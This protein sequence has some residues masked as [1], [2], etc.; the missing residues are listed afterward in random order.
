MN[1]ERI[2][3]VEDDRLALRILTSKFRE[4]GYQVVPATSAPDA[5]SAVRECPPDLMI[6][7]LTLLDDDPFNTLS[8]GFACLHW[9]RRSFPETE[10]PVIIHTADQS[11]NLDGR[12]LENGVSAVFRKGEDLNE[13][14]NTVRRVI[15]GW[16]AA[17]PVESP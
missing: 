3:I 1:S 14:V 15:D 7:D 12:A 8:D 5:V 10:F 6:L 13:L 2:L 16:Q 17:Q 4:A 9:L 11:E